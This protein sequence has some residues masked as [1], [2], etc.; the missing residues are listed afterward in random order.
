MVGWPDASRWNEKV[1]PIKTNGK[2]MD[3]FNR[4]QLKI[5]QMRYSAVLNLNPNEQA[6]S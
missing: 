1:A 2:N 6:D 5:N 4:K 3:K